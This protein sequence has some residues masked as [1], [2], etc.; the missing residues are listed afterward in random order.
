MLCV[1][2]GETMKFQTAQSKLI[3]VITVA[4]ILN[5]KTQD[6]VFSQIT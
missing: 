3:T 5:I 2:S 1:Q 6:Q 4:K